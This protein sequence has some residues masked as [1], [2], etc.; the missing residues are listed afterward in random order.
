MIEE[1]YYRFS[2]TADEVYLCLANCLG[3]NENGTNDCAEGSRGPLCSLCDRVHYLHASTGH[4]LSC[5]TDWVVPLLG[6]LAFVLVCAGIAWMRA[7]IMRWAARHQAWLP[8][9]GHTFFLLVVMMQII[10][11][12]KHN[13]TSVGGVEISEPYAT[14]VVSR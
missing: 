12:L 14:F 9:F 5:A 4:C 3:S 2:N 13:H 6:F 11:I 1:G 7:R 10:V 8:T